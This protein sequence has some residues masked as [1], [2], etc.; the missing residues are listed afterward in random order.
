MVEE[1]DKNKEKNNSELD[2]ELE[3][4]KAQFIVNGKK[5][6]NER[7]KDYLKIIV[8]HCRISPEGDI[9]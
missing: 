7:L 1:I 6:E 2:Q 8:K 5:F 4:L 3:K 9:C